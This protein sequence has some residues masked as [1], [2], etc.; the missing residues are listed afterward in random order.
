MNKR[1]IV[2]AQNHWGIHKGKTGTVTHID[3]DCNLY[4]DWD[5]NYSAANGPWEPTA[6]AVVGQEEIPTDHAL[7]HHDVNLH[8]SE[9]EL[10]E[11]LIVAE[12]KNTNSQNNFYY[13]EQLFDLLRKVQVN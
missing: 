9:L 5:D 8:D 1:V 10:I 13:V 3:D 6:F 7:T 2:T 11:S 4:V 12:I